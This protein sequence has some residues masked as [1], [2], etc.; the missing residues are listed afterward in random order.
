MRHRHVC[1][2]G[3]WYVCRDPDCL[4]GS[5]EQCP[6]CDQQQQDELARERA[7]RTLIT[8]R[9]LTLTAK[10]MNRHESD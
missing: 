10:D 9:S 5:F 4:P 7:Y 1:S 2:C 8:A 3:A 6:E